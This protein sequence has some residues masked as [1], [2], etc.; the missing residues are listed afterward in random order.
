MPFDLIAFPESIIHPA[1]F[2]RAG[3]N[4]TVLYDIHTS[5]QANAASFAIN[6]VKVEKRWQVACHRKE[7]PGIP[8]QQGKGNPYLQKRM[9]RCGAEEIKECSWRPGPQNS[10]VAREPE[11]C[12]AA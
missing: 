6:I 7:S 4:R 5:I 10:A 12:Y 1:S 11:C 3:K 8:Q 9:N 2:H